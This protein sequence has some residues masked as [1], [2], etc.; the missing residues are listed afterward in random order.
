VKTEG[1]ERETEDRLVISDPPK[2]RRT[3]PPNK[4]ADKQR[5][6]GTVIPAKPKFSNKIEPESQT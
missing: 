4:M 1:G 5:K 6:K 2:R 3:G